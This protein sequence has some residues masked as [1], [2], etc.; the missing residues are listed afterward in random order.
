MDNPTISDA[1]VSDSLSSP[2]TI[3]R[4][5]TLNKLGDLNTDFVA[6]DPSNAFDIKFNEIS[7]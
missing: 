1:M 7:Q 2:I 5:T 4:K 6:K 3:K